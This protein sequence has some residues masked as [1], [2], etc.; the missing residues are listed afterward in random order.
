MSAGFFNVDIFP[1]FCLK[2]VP[3]CGNGVTKDLA[4]RS[5]GFRCHE[6]HIFD[7][8]DVRYQS[9]IVGVQLAEL[10]GD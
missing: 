1:R 4:E 3:F 10:F 6:V 2:C 7:F 8:Q 9:R 5:S